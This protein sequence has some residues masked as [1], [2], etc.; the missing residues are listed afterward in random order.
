MR[1]LPGRSSPS[2]SCA[3]VSEK[4]DREMPHRTPARYFFDALALSFA[5]RSAPRSS[6][7]PSPEISGTHSDPPNAR[8]R[9]PEPDLGTLLSLVSLAVVTTATVVVFFGLGFFLLTAPS[10]KLIAGPDAR[11]RG[12]EIEARPF[13]LAPSPNKNAAPFTAHT[14][15]SHP[16]TASAPTVPPAQAPDAHEVLPS[17]D[18]SEGSLPA[19]TAG[20]AVANAKFD[21]SS[22]QELPGLRLNSDEATLAT[23]TAAIH[24]KRTAIGGHRHHEARTHSAGRSH[25]G[26]KVRPPPSISGPEK[27]W[28]WIVR[29]ATSVLAALSPRPS[30]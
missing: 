23:P 11:E 15:V 10:G 2:V 13:D 28:R 24:A 7:P 19:S 17:R 8:T 16:A 21:V 6:D 29:S 9:A 18:P 26:A 12:V 20:S 14:E 5:R 1:G 30:Q 3:A 4:S 27:A 22:S 25:T